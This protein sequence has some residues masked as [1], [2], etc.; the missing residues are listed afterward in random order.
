MYINKL[1]DNIFD[2]FTF[3]PIKKKKKVKNGVL[4]ELANSM[5]RELPIV[6]TVGFVFT[7][8]VYLVWG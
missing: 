7:A 3:K 8:I 5:V 6:V 4:N 1:I 2:V